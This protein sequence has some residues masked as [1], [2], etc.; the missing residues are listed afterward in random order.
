MARSMKTVSCLQLAGGSYSGYRPGA[1]WPLG[2]CQGGDD[3]CDL[4][5]PFCFRIYQC[6]AFPPYLT[7]AQHTEA[8]KIVSQAPLYC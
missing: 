6:R 2:L 4:K 5:A 7:L 3:I 1:K 8:Q